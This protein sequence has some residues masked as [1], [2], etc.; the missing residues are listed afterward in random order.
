ME[1]SIELLYV[2]VTRFERAASCSRSKRSTK[3]SHTSP[4][5][6]LRQR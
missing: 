4:W 1:Y 2:E 6:T 3:L 5:L